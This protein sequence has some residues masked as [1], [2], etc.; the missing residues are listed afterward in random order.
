MTRKLRFRLGFGMPDCLRITCITSIWKVYFLGAIG[1][2]HDMSEIPTQFTKKKVSTIQPLQL[3][4]LQQKGSFPKGSKVWKFETAV[5]AGFRLPTQQVPAADAA[6]PFTVDRFEILLPLKDYRIG[7]RTSQKQGFELSPGIWRFPMTF[8]ET[9]CVGFPCFPW[10]G[11]VVCNCFFCWL[12][13]LVFSPVSEGRLFA[14]GWGTH[15]PHPAPAIHCS[16]Q[17]EP[18]WKTCQPFCVVKKDCFFFGFLFLAKCVGILWYFFGR[19]RG[20]F[21]GLYYPDYIGMIIRHHKDP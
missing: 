2:L 12:P 7:Q 8:G 6:G 14:A 9:K 11:F 1:S 4:F 18:T 21:Y 15:W 17:T 13:Q 10:E 5:L 16:P 20:L 19:W 3:S